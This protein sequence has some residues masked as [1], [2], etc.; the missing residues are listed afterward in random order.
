MPADRKA[1]KKNCYE[2][3]IDVRRLKNTIT[4]ILAGRRPWAKTLKR[5]DLGEREL[6]K[7]RS[8]DARYRT[9]LEEK[10]GVDLESLY[11]GKTALPE[12][13][14]PDVHVIKAAPPPKYDYQQGLE[15]VPA[16]GLN[17]Y[18][19]WAMLMIFWSGTVRMH[20]MGSSAARIT[21]QDGE[22]VNQTYKK[23]RGMRTGRH[24]S[25]LWISLI[26]IK[27]RMPSLHSGIPRR[28]CIGSPLL[29]KIRMLRSR[30]TEQKKRR[31]KGR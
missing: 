25:R 7:I 18:T 4:S 2:A 11:K 28:G 31:Q 5:F 20:E 24:S 1:I 17:I 15:E 12:M 22:L 10:H 6:N 13:W 16:Q 23:E 8:V 14:L 30:P 3:N 19:T 26:K 21:M 27:I 29:D 9:M